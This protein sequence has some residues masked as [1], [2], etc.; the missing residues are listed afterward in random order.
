MIKLKEQQG[1]KAHNTFHINATASLLCTIA[2]E[3][4]AID[5]FRLPAY[6]QHQSIIV[7]SGS[8]ILFTKDFA[9]LVVHNALKGIR[10]IE[11]TAGHV[12]LNV[13]SGELW[14]SVVMHCVNNDWGGIENLSLIPG[15]VGAAPMQN[16]GA[17]GAE[18]KDVIV[19]VGAIE[20]S[21]GDKRIFSADECH[22]GYRESIFKHDLKQKYFIS[23]VTL[24]LTKKN[25]KLNTSYGAITET[26]ATM[27]DS[28]PSVQSISAAVIAIRRSKLPDPEVI[29]NA[30]S[31]F[32]NPVISR[33]Q[34]EEL[35]KSHP[36]LPGYFSENQSVKVP[37][38][39]L[40]EKDG[41]KGK[42]FGDAGVHTHHALVLV[43]YNDAKGS[44]IFEL[45]MK[46]QSSVKAKFDIML[47][48]EVNII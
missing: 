43:N 37:A 18:I 14:H 48:P 29:G 33:E 11:E 26:L 13:A 16:I 47:T 46:I 36:T 19:N 44:D 38:A 28:T 4:D 39:W 3:D 31:F 2:S 45:A 40:I 20:C 27:N 21:S 41:W 15:T 24:R 22:F 32:K 25:H 1:L 8:N 5:L 30:G 34:Y 6:K 10:I 9:G 35:K 12:V 23:S 42:R 7:G 17:Y